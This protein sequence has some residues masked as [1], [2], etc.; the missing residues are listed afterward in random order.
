MSETPTNGRGE[1]PGLT[2]PGVAQV[3]V[4]EVDVLVDRY[5]TARDTRMEHTKREVEAKGNLVAAL[6]ANAD[7][8]G[9]TPGGDIV[10]H[11]DD[12]VV[13]LA[14][15]KEKLKVRTAGNEEEEE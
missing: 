10:Y 12:L 3:R 2:G 6:H 5:V 14:T 8:I 11:Y 13:T 7:A 1:L 4:P 9:R 15:G